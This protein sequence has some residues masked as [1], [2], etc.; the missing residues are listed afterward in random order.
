MSASQPQRAEWLEPQFWDRLARLESRHRHVLCEHDSARRQLKRL[1]SREMQELRSAWRR[2]CQ[3]I[4]E[5]DQ[6]TAE[7]ES[8]RKCVS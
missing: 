8:L 6:T 7:L 4:F 3:V 2:Y 1:T 5:L